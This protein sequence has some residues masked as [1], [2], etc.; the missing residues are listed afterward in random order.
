M[1]NNPIT[2]KDGWVP[3][4][5]LKEL[6]EI[7]KLSMELSS[8]PLMLVK[9][10]LLFFQTLTD[11]SNNL[12][13]KYQSYND[14]YSMR[15]LQ[16]HLFRRIWLRMT[17]NDFLNVEQFLK[18]QLSFLN[19]NTF[20]CYRKEKMIA[21]L[22][23]YQVWVQ[24]RMATMWDEGNQCLDFW[25]QNDCQKY[26]LPSILFDIENK[27]K[28]AYL[29]AVQTN[30]LSYQRQ[31]EKTP[32]NLD[33]P[34]LS[35]YLYKDKKIERFL[36]KMN[37]EIDLKTS[38]DEQQVENLKQFFP[39]FPLVVSIFFKLLN[40]HG[41]NE[42][43]VPC[44]HVLSYN[45]HLLLSTKAKE[46]WKREYCLERLN[47][48]HYLSDDSKEY[49]RNKYYHDSLWYQHVVGKKDII[50][51]TKTENLFWLLKRINYHFPNINILY[52]P[53]LNMDYF[54]VYIKN[55]WNEKMNCCLLKNYLDYLSEPEGEKKLTLKE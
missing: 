3:T 37:K 2:C 26:Y 51:K 46:N 13:K 29:Q 9:Q 16:I 1:F 42:I 41:I 33:D 47:H 19:D 8:Y 22:G 32:L 54:D 27:T 45:Y 39:S 44:Y 53:W 36:Y 38:L 21:K 23:E 4:I 7:K 40:K 15:P 25:L 5:G 17:P 43:K 6:N 10:P 28:I 34:F 18:Q 24:L 12:Y 50:I 11:I 14:C 48:Y 49:K 52:D 35:P 31:E 30:K 20:D 55:F